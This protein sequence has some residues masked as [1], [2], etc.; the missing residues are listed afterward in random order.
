MRIVQIAP[1]IGPGKGIAGVAWSLDRAFRAAGVETESFTFSAARQGKPWPVAT[2]PFGRRVLRAW[3]VIWFSVVGTRRARAFLAARPDAIAIC[4]SEVLAGDIFVSHGVMSI[5]AKTRARGWW[6][7][8]ANPVRAFTYLRDRHRFRSGIHDTVVVLSDAEATALDSA[9]GP[10]APRVKVI[11]NGV[12]LERFRPPTPA[13]RTEARATFRLTDDAR[14]ALLIGHDLLRKG[15]LTAVDA[16]V[17]APSVLLMVVGGDAPSIEATRERAEANGV[18]DRVLFAG[19]RHDI[20]FLMA[21]SDVFLFPST[22]EANALVVLEALACGLP[23]I[24]TRVGYAPQ[25]IVDGVNGWLVPPDAA[26]IGR[27]LEIAAAI[28]TGML[29]EHARASVEDLGWAGVAQRYV[30]LAEQVA[31]RRHGAADRAT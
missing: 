25:I 24:C 9:Y 12:D 15:S 31:A 29:R 2:R 28:D 23:A 19:V 10:V 30:V 13:E 22:Y 7:L 18:Q 17:H 20:P 3:R 27:Q 8:A 6:H 14:V 16:L 11:P 26:L 5:A 4:H 21:A 1:F